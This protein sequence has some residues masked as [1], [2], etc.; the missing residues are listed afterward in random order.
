MRLGH[1][2]AGTFA[3][4]LGLVALPLVSVAPAQAQGRTAVILSTG[5]VGG[6]TVSCGCKSKDLGGL[7]RRAT[8]IAEQRAEYPDLLLVD[9]GDFGSPDD[10]EPWERT[11][12]VWQAMD[13]LGYDV[14]TVGPNEMA[15]GLGPLQALLATA[16]D[17]AVVSANVTD[18]NGNLVWPDYVMVEKGGITYAITG[19]TDGSYYKFNLSRGVQQSDDFAFQDSREALQRVLPQLQDADVVVALLQMS[20]GDAR[21]VT[22]GLEGIDV[23]VVG[24]NA[25]YTYTPELMNEILFVRGGTRGQYLSTLTLSLDGDR[26]VDYNGRGVPLSEGVREESQL[27]AKVDAF[28]SSYDARKTAAQGETETKAEAGS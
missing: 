19:A 6:E 15:A 9:A 14:A 7:A 22:E 5:S 12:F 3:A 20:F 2:A 23:V 26:I 24:H 11:T 16:P 21:R 17:I 1:A 28:N 4:L 18:K 10:F 13:D 27:K 8:V 25:G